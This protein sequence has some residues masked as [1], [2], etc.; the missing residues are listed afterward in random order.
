MTVLPRVH[1]MG[2]ARVTQREGWLDMRRV[3]R[4]IG[5]MA[6]R[7][8]AVAAHSVVAVEGLLPLGAD[9]VA[10]RRHLESGL[11]DISAGPAEPPGWWIPRAPGEQIA[12]QA[13]AMVPE[14]FTPVALLS[15]PGRCAW[16]VTS[17]APSAG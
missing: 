15:S 2:T 17:A 3:L 1:D 9:G 12:G 6:A 5:R 11:A 7:P 13:P 16:S 10:P 14:R 8:H 4:E